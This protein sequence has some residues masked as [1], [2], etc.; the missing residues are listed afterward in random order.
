MQKTSQY[1]KFMYHREYDEPRRVDTKEQENDLK[2]K[3]W[4]SRYLYKE[5]PKMVN[6]ILCKSADQEKL[7]LEASGQQAQPCEVKV[8]KVMVGPDGS[9]I[10]EDIQTEPIPKGSVQVPE[11]F[12]SD[13]DGDMYEIVNADGA[14]VPDHLYDNWADARAAQKDLNANTPGHKARKVAQV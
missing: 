6:G 12:E 13:S 8:K 1:P 7:L 4:V 5:Y 11:T 14:V 9:P 3:G 2:N 10:D